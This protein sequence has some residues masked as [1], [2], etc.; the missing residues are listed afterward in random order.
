VRLP[1]GRFEIIE[2]ETFDVILDGAHNPHAAV[3]LAAELQARSIRPTLIVAV[4]ADKHVAGIASALAPVARHVIATRY[5]QDRA[6][7][8]DDLATAFRT[9]TTIAPTVIAPTAAASVETAPDLAAALAR[10][11]DPQAA[12][13]RDF[14]PSV[15]APRRTIII[16]GSLFLVGEARVQL[17]GA[18]A[19]PYVVTDPTPKM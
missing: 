8:P 10:A 2:G 4:S 15:I 12:F 5:Q 3:A 6:L 13:N 1:P 16:T 11:R 14:S 17:L 7:S 19:D 18:P 9:A